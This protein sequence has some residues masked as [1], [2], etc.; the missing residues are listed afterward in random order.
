MTKLRVF[1][2]IRF[3]R[4]PTNLVCADLWSNA[5]C[6]ITPEFAYFLV[7]TLFLAPSGSM[8][9]HFSF[10]YTNT[11]CVPYYAFLIPIS[12]TMV[13]QILQYSMLF[14]LGPPLVRK[15][16]AFFKADEKFLIN[17][18]HIDKIKQSLAQTCERCHVS[19]PESILNTVMSYLP[20]N[21]DKESQYWKKYGPHHLTHKRATFALK[22]PRPHN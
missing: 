15:A 5:S 17:Q 1:C 22:T 4:L 16:T 20:G 14:L 18:Q 12:A 9:L 19:L 2:K 10:T 7:F 13:I 6:Q 8:T 11:L 21:K 3:R